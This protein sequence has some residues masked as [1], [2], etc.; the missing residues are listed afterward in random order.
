MQFILYKLYN[1]TDVY[2]KHTERF[3]SERTAFQT[4]GRQGEQG[5]T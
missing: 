5:G 2:V 4:Q 3:Y 1:N